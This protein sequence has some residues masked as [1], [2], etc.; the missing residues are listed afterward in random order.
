MDEDEVLSGTTDEYTEAK[1]REYTG[2]VQTGTIRQKIIN[3]DGSTYI[4]I[5]YDRIRYSITFDSN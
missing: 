3:G 2:L 5:F 1:A 4:R